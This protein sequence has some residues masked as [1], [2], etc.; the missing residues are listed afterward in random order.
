[1]GVGLRWIKIRIALVKADDENVAGRAAP[2]VA[3]AGLKEMAATTT[4][5]R[6][7]NYALR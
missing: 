4:V 2:A 7:R 6:K 5:R 3:D 1:V